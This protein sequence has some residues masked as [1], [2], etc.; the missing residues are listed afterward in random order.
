MRAEA[1]KAL[2][3]LNLG[4]FPLRVAL[5]SKAPQMPGWQ[6]TRPTEESIARQ[7]AIP[8]N[9]GIRTGDIHPDGS[10]LA[11]IDIDL[12][13]PEIV[14]CVERAIGRPVPVKQ[15]RKG[16]TYFVRLAEQ[17]PSRKIHFYRNGCKRPAID[18]QCRA[19][20]TVIPPS[21]H[22]ETRLPYRWVTGLALC[23]L[24]YDDLPLLRSTVIDEIA[25]FCKNAD[26]PI[27]ALN[28]ME[29]RGVSGGGDTHD[30]C[31]AAVASMVSRGWP[32][33]DI[34]DRIDRA[35]REACE[36]ASMPYNWPQAQR[37]IQEW[38][39]SARAK[40]GASGKSSK[41]V[42]HGALADAFLEKGGRPHPL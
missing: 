6:T 3:Y 13:G 12:E 17:M 9:L 23:D 8:S 40:F 27:Y 16:Y 35:K 42:S 36:T 14:R 41:K 28:D 4:Y 2:Q 38:I 11:A 5:G 32:D 18:F 34:H 25:G 26:D 31:V 15:G 33:E 1:D 7:F 24:P 20:Q 30:T 19:A 22:P 21:I 29:W 10:C 37:T 39:D